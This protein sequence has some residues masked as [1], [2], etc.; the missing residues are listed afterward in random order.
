M[1]AICQ[2]SRPDISASHVADG[3]RNHHAKQGAAFPSRRRTGKLPRGRR[4]GRAVRG[5]E[6]GAWMGR[7]GSWPNQP[8]RPIGMG[9]EGRKKER[10]RGA[11]A[12]GGRLLGPEEREE[13]DLY[14]AEKKVPRLSVVCPALLPAVVLH[15]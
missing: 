2:K 7:R 4:K 11:A 12:A 13:E 15:F 3:L 5:L 14:A 8:S 10:G 6:D 1:E 9:R